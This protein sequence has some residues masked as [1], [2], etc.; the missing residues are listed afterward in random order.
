[1][2]TISKCL[3]AACSVFQG[4]IA[5]YV[6]IW[7]IRRR[8]WRV[9]FLKLLFAVDLRGFQCYTCIT[10]ENQTVCFPSFVL[11]VFW[12]STSYIAKIVFWMTLNKSVDATARWW[13]CACLTYVSGLQRR[14]KDLNF[15]ICI[16]FIDL[17][18]KYCSDIL[19]VIV[20][21]VFGTTF[22]SGAFQII[23]W[24]CLVLHFD[25]NV[26]NWIPKVIW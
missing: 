5:R 22:F 24:T 1:M 2:Y 25:G 6:Q 18:L 20:A 12:C 4:I 8:C 11:T 16:L 15:F 9:R 13:P 10:S 7:R 19:M 17:V 3:N 26:C 14:E 21:F 23:D